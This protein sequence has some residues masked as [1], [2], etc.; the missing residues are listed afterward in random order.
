MKTTLILL[1][2]AFLSASLLSV[3][4]TTQA[5][6]I[7][8][9]GGLV[10][11]TTH[12]ITWLADANYAKTSGYDADGRMTWSQAMTWAANLS[13]YDSV[14]KK[15]L[16]GWRLP[17]TLELDATCG[18][19]YGSYSSGGNCTGSE[20]GY[21]F[22]N[23]LGGVLGQSI[24]ATHNNNYNLFQNIQPGF[25]WSG[26]VHAPTLTDKIDYLQRNDPSL[27]LNFAWRFNFN[28]GY[29]N[30]DYQA[31][32][33]SALAVRDGDVATPIYLSPGE[34]ATI[35]FAFLAPPHEGVDYIRL[36]AAASGLPA[37][38]SVPSQ[39][40]IFNGNSLLGTYQG[41][42]SNLNFLGQWTTSGSLFSANLPL[43][44][45][46]AIRNGSIDGKMILKNTSATDVVQFDPAN[47]E[48]IVSTAV[49]PYATNTD[50]T[51]QPVLTSVVKNSNYVP[52]PPAPTKLPLP[53]LPPVPPTTK[54]DAKLGLV[55]VVHGW[56]SNSEG[57]PE[58]MAT[59]IKSAIQAG[60]NQ[61]IEWSVGVLD[62]GGLAR[63][64]EPWVS[65]SNAFMVGEWLANWISDRYDYLHLIAHSAGSN[66][67]QVATEKLKTSR[68]IKQPKIHL[69]FLDAFHP[70]P[71]NSTYGRFADWA[72][73]Y[74]DRS[75]LTPV[76]GTDAILIDA[77]NFDITDWT[78]QPA[79][80]P[81][82]LPCVHRWPY[83]WYQ[84]SI[85][86]SVGTTPYL[87]GYSRS[88]E[89]GNSL[90][91][92]S[93]FFKRGALCTLE[94]IFSDCL[95][96]IS[97]TGT[98]IKFFPEALVTTTS[99]LVKKTYK[100]ATGLV[101][102]VKSVIDDVGTAIDIINLL[103]G[104][105]VWITLELDLPMEISALQ[106]DYQFGGIG[107]G[108]LT[109]YLDNQRVYAA[110][111]R[112]GSGVK[113]STGPFSI[114]SVSA[115]KHFL[116]FR[117]DNFDGPPSSIDL[118]GI[119]IGRF[120]RQPVENEL[121]IAVAGDYRTVRVKSNV[122]LDGSGSYDPD[123]TASSLIFKWWQV[124]GPAITLSSPT[125]ARPLLTPLAP[126]K[127][128][129]NLSVNDGLVDSLPTSVVISVPT[130]GDIDADGD[131]DND[132]L[133][134]ILAARGKPANGP[135]DLRDLDGD[136]MIT[137]LDARKLTTLCTRP[138]C[139]T[140]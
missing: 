103:T 40:D 85:N 84:D 33:Y 112:N 63:N 139:A 90:P 97:D 55:L 114:G 12:N 74:V 89:A 93:G 86:Y 104:S 4:G 121:P 71:D 134:L 73:Q 91:G 2:A 47:V 78:P 36:G 117:L 115:G 11:D 59:S 105:P 13:Y 130:L 76:P 25:Y 111:Q 24:T 29:Q 35:R 133:N 7:D 30:Y 136:G 58:N 43:I 131:V 83:E 75:M 49:G 128:V 106:F 96:T 16:T 53:V 3:G 10:Y 66:V 137:A 124:S 110:D 54:V 14:H 80:V 127:Y 26:T 123:S 37:G 99:S 15:T 116:S 94:N 8:R 77:F 122:V 61:N 108:L 22:Y 82:A 129:F 118:S 79:C 62:W 132:D 101:S 27:S 41:S 50:M 92:H 56:N 57:W 19:Q 20:M 102:E 32:S 107:E 120:A 60:G 17:T 6:L 45:F 100:S 72:E 109:V 38:P 126:G 81:G 98:T 95:P 51:K 140:Q 135:N 31:Y 52:T 68:D 88:V 64:L 23:E 48:V 44:D 87:F 138:R 28:S 18:S 70:E 39:V 46:T 125:V 113:N 69:T 1:A 21:L 42:F 65:W 67:I 34:S 9:G 119:T 5:A